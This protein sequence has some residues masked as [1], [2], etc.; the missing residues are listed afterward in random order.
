MVKLQ[1]IIYNS[2]TILFLIILNC[3][4]CESKFTLTSSSGS[5]SALLTRKCPARRL[6]PINSFKSDI[7]DND[8][9]QILNLRV[10]VAVTLKRDQ[11]KRFTLL[12]TEITPLE[13]SIRTQQDIQ[14]KAIF[15]DKFL[16]YNNSIIK[17]DSRD[18]FIPCAIPGIYDI[19]LSFRTTLK[20]KKRLNVKIEAIDAHPSEQWSLRNRSVEVKLRTQNRIQKKQMILKWSKSKLDVHNVQYCMIVNDIKPRENFCESVGD[21]LQKRYYRVRGDCSYLTPDGIWFKQ[22]KKIKEIYKNFTNIICT[23]KKTQQIISALEVNQKYYVDIF[24]IHLGY[25]NLPFLLKSTVVWFNKTHPI[26]LK[27]NSLTIEKISGITSNSVFSFKIPSYSSVTQL[28]YLILPCGGSQVDAKILRNRTKL[29]LETNIY[30]PTFVTLSNGVERN[31][32]YILRITPS[33]VDE[34]LKANKVGVAVST[35]NFRDYIPQMPND[36]TITEIRSARTCDNTTKIA[37]Y[38]S[39][40]SREIEYCAIVLKF[41]KIQRSSSETNYCM[42]F[43]RDNIKRHPLFHYMKCVPGEY[44]NI[45]TLQLYNFIPE[46]SYIVYVTIRLVKNEVIANKAIPYESI[47]I[48]YNF[49]SDCINTTSVT[50]STYDY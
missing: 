8:M 7:N 3:A 44:T 6:V 18:I 2:F 46:Y 38:G 13:I 45:E 23:G 37:W 15:V 1:I 22:R 40:D 42:D 5:S 39:P 49:N 14:E 33:N 10:Q 43:S 48:N 41:P 29:L 26:V 47:K 21:S 4:Y 19:V 35:D 17:N 11:P 27:D 16:Y 24:G 34:I 12:L 36:T 31:G 28:T 32:R 25:R 20:T 50:P 30:K 9:G